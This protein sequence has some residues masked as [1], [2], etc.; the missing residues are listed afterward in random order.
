[1]IED[2]DESTLA[3]GRGQLPKF[4]AVWE[5]AQ[6]EVMRWIGIKKLSGEDWFDYVALRF[7]E[8]STLGK[9]SFWSL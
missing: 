5:N 4:G 3:M 9:E 6:V 7:F 8:K 1:V 2:V